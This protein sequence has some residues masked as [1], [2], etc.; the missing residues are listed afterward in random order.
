MLQKIKEFFFGKKEV[1]VV[2]VPKKAPAKKAAA[3]KEEK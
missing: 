2:E 3:K 1:P